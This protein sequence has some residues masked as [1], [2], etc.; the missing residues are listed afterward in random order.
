MGKRCKR[1]NKVAYRTKVE[2]LGVAAHHVTFAEAE[3][4]AYRD[5]RCDGWHL[6]TKSIDTYKRSV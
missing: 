1:C 4:R 3:M 2:A 5:E 6:T